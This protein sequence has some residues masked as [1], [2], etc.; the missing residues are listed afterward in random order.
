MPP[1]SRKR[2]VRS[3]EPPVKCTLCCRCLKSRAPMLL[4]GM[5]CCRKLGSLYLRGAVGE[6]HS[7]KASRCAARL[8]ELSMEAQHI[9]LKDRVANT[10]F[11]TDHGLLKAPQEPVTQ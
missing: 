4:R 3:L 7:R 2:Q 6:E 8:K 10:S 5:A 1:P 9:P 11:L